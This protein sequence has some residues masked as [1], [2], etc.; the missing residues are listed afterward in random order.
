MIPLQST[1]WLSI[2][3]KSWQLLPLWLPHCFPICNPS[4][5]SFSISP[6]S[7][8]VSEAL[9]SWKLGG[10]LC[11]FCYLEPKESDRGQRSSLSFSDSSASEPS[12]S[13][14]LSLSCSCCR[15]TGSPSTMTSFYLNIQYLFS[16]PGLTDYFSWLFWL[17]IFHCYVLQ[18]S[19]HDLSVTCDF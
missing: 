4:I 2:T 13:S 18:S 15:K 3:E 11:F 8:R 7:V 10:H 17:V 14:I 1:F 19:S 6:F 5:F 12:V 16:Y 9:S